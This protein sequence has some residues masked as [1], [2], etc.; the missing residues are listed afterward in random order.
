MCLPLLPSPSLSRLR[1]VPLFV[2]IRENVFSNKLVAYLVEYVPDVN[3]VVILDNGTTNTQSI[4]GPVDLP[5]ML[6]AYNNVLTKAYSVCS[7][8]SAV[9]IIGALTVEWKS[10]KG[11]DIGMGRFTRS[12]FLFSSSR[13]SILQRKRT[14]E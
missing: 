8:M 1:V 13:L 10:V 14:I 7:C 12:I 2:S 11:K 6:L 4:I 3:L 5:G 9:S